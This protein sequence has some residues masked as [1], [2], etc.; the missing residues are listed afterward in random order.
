MHQE[1]RNAIA[2]K[3]HEHSIVTESNNDNIASH[4]T[5]MYSDDDQDS[6]YKSRGFGLNSKAH[7]N[8][9]ERFRSEKLANSVDNESRSRHGSG[10]SPPRTGS[11][12][13]IKSSPN[14]N[15]SCQN[16]TGIKGILD[17]D[18]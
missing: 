16:E 12:E 11:Q 9:P 2:E 5:P 18:E 10:Q 7:I 4:Y 14:F 15:K 13:L 1:Q 6:V 17:I 3:D 8:N